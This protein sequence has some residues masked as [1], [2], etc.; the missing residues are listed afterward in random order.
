MSENISSHLIFFLVVTGILVVSGCIDSQKS[1]PTPTATP[2]TPTPTATPP[3]PTIAITAPRE[4]NIVSYRY[5]VSGTSSGVYGSELSI[6][7][8]IYPIEVGGPWWVQPMIDISPNGNWETNV[9]F[10]RDPAQYP[11][12]SGKHFRI[13]AVITSIKL[14]EGQQWQKMPDY[15]VKDEVRVTRE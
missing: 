4:G 7:V 5:I 6:Y 15:I 11:E 13:S 8:L 1:T 9:Y 12:D 3:T 2:P 14:K 10:G